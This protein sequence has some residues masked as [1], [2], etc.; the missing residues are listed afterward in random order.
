MIE[1]DDMRSRM[2]WLIPL[3]CLI[4]L[5]CKQENESQNTATSTTTAT[6]TAD[7]QVSRTNA[8]AQRTRRDPPDKV[9]EPA[10]SNC[11]DLQPSDFDVDVVLTGLMMFIPDDLDI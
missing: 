1:G 6:A 5:G 9:A 11:S 3:F 4:V 2:P 8:S 7:T 10:R